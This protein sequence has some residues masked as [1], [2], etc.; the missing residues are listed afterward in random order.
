MQLTLSSLFITIVFT[1]I[2]ILI[3]NALLTCKKSYMFFRTDFLS[4]LAIIIVLRLLFPI[5]FK[6]TQSIAATPIM[7]PFYNIMHYKFHSF[8]IYNLL[9][10][11]WVI[12]IIIK[13]IEYIFSISQSNKNYKLLISNS[14]KLETNDLDAE[15]DIF[16]IFSSKFLYVPTVFTT[17]K[18]IFL[19]TTLYTKS[20]L[21]N[22]LRHEISH[23]QHHDGL[24]K[25][26]INLVVILYWWNP[27]V[28]IFRNQIHLLLE[29]CADYK[30]T[31]NFN[32]VE[33]NQ[34]I[35]DLINIQKKTTIYNQ[36][37]KYSNSNIIDE[38]IKVLE[39]RINYMIENK[40]KKKTNK[41][42][43]ATLI[44]FPF[45]TN[46]IIL[47]PSF[48]A[49]DEHELLSEKDLKNGY[50]T[51]NKDGTYTFHVGKFKGIINNP[52]S[53]EF[54]DIPVIKGE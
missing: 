29:M 36:V 41:L 53:K 5:E 10:L 42:L 17:K 49:P 43:L 2:L 13:S 6:F 48:P 33:N 16:P 20:E 52:K 24:I 38:S 19:P 26:I 7:N 30:S 44:L 40:Y 23:I 27:F 3:F 14:V 50:I 31:K 4:V 21:N 11:I 18:S 15:L 28:Y 12:G 54:K 9:L 34:Y 37:H 22:I 35:R 1:A 39:Y 47:E 45:L 32:E 25:H 46:S 51:V 8:E